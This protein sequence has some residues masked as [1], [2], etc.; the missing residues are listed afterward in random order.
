[1]A[2]TIAVGWSALLEGVDDGV[3]LEAGGVAEYVGE[4][5]DVVGQV[6]AVARLHGYAGP[7]RHI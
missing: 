1:L 6:G 7:V 4:G 3:H 5:G 2:N